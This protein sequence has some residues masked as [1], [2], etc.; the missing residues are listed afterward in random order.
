[1]ASVKIEQ[2]EYL[3]IK[4]DP[5]IGY[6][7]PVDKVTQTD[8]KTKEFEIKLQGNKGAETENY[9]SQVQTQVKPLIEHRNGNG[10]L[11]VA[12]EH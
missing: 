2:N 9:D 7:I 5:Q 11:D 6:Y 10:H 3:I 4:H 12:E 1:M 8:G